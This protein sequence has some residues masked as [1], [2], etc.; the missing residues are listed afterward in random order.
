[1]AQDLTVSRK[2]FLLRIVASV[3][4]QTVGEQIPILGR[5][6]IGRDSRCT[7]SLADTSVSREHAR[8]ELVPDGIR[9]IDLN[10]QNGVWVDSQ[11][12]TDVV[13]HVGDRCSIGSNVLECRE[14][15]SGPPAR[16]STTVRDWS[17]NWPADR[18]RV[19][20]GELSILVVAGGEN[21][22]AAD[23]NFSS[24]ANREVGRG[25]DCSVV[26]DERDVSRQN[27]RIEVA[28]GGFMVS[29]LESLAGVYLGD[30]R[31]STEL[32]PPE[33]PIRLGPRVT[34]QCRVVREV[35]DP[36]PGPVERLI[37]RAS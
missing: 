1:M 22:A 36:I 19:A 17:G 8:F 37:G 16:G 18:P 7:L 13:L 14:E 21:V 35:A 29:D 12:L 2:L 10:S 23:R 3:E 31:I 26:I 33:T 32:I 24:K 30:R 5:V 27:A 6:Y 4:G 11:R 25:K 28:P 9:I 34:I 15:V 20:G